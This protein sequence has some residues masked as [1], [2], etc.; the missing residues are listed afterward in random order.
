M[1]EVNVLLVT[2]TANGKYFFFYLTRM[3]G[4]SVK[5]KLNEF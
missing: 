5:Y 1:N 3:Q 4:F 2:T